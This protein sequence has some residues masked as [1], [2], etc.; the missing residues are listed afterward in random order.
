LSF[1]DLTQPYDEHELYN[2]RW[3]ILGLFM[4]FAYEIQFSPLNTAYLEY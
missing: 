4:K 2:T 3:V 1:S